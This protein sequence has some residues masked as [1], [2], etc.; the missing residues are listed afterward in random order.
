MTWGRDTDEVAARDQLGAFLTAGGNLID[1][2][3]VY[4]DG[5]SERVLGRLLAEDNRRERVVLATKSVSRPGTE[6]RFDASSKHLCASLEGSLRRLGTDH[7]DLWQ[8]H[9]WDPWTPL[10]ETLSAID[11]AVSTGKVRYVGVSNYAGWQLSQAATK[12]LET[13]GAPIISTQMEYSFLQRGIEREVV[14]AAKELGIGILPWSPLGRGVLTGKYR[15]ST[16]TDSRGASPTFASFVEPYLDDGSAAIVDAVA[17]A[18]E[19]LNV[20][21]A[22]VALAWVRDQ[23]GVAAPIIGARTVAQLEQALASEELTIPPAL[24]AALDEVSAPQKGYPEFG[25]NQR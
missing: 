19:G 20:S 10:D 17:T 23:P 21:P 11:Q 4:A 3:D 2:A 15:H 9:A 14:P 7:I 24:A 13:S 8:L 18:A 16:P 25:W 6:R 22:Q 1:T 12:Q 5:A